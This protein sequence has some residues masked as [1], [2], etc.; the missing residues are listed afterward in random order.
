MEG[1]QL[2]VHRRM[3]TAHAQGLLAAASV[4][5]QGTVPVAKQPTGQPRAYWMPADEAT[6]CW[7]SYAEMMADVILTSLT[8]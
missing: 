5:M 6:G 7:A 4:P 1:A 2:A 8:A 3:T